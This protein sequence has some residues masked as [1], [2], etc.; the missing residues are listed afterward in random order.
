MLGYDYFI[1][2]VVNNLIQF[3]KNYIFKTKFWSQVTSLV[4]VHSGSQGIN[5]IINYD[6]L[7]HLKLNLF[8]F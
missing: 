6:E 2:S 4:L 5:T 8:L 7:L 1:V 3:K